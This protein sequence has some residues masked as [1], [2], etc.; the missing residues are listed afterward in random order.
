MK[1]RREAGCLH[2]EREGGGTR[3]ASTGFEPG[4]CHNA[5]NMLRGLAITLVLTSV[6]IRLPTRTG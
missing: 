4:L 6:G 2:P 1:P 5:T 3:T